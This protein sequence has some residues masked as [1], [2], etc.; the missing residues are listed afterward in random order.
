MFK[1][2]FARRRAQKDAQVDAEYGHVTSA[3]RQELG[4]MRGPAFLNT[5][6][7]EHEADREFNNA[8]GRP[9]RY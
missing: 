5:R 8:E 6:G 9:R 7:I 3:E 1:Q 4:E 2:F